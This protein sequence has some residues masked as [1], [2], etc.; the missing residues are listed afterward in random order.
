M[1]HVLLVDDQPETIKVLTRIASRVDGVTIH[2]CSD[3]REAQRIIDALDV[4]DVACVDLLLPFGSG[5]DVA[6]AILHKWPSV[7]VAIMLGVYSEDFRHSEEYRALV[8][9]GVS[10]VVAKHSITHRKWLEFWI[11]AAANP[12]E[13][14]WR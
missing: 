9:L 13:I 3:V 14:G 12:E 11:H 4:V 2:A 10:A 5:R 7:P 1:I 6:R 8:A